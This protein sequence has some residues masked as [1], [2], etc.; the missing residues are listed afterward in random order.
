MLATPEAFGREAAIGELYRIANWWLDK[1]LDVE[2]GGFVGEIDFHGN[3]VPGASKGVILN[4]RILW[5]FSELAQFDNDVRYLDAANRAFN[6]LLEYFDD[7]VHGGAVWELSADGIILNGRKQVYAQCFCIYALTA[8][9]RLTSNP[10]ALAKALEYFGRLESTALDRKFGGFIDAFSQSWKSIDD[11]RLSAND[12]NVPKSMNTHLHVLE[13]YTALYKT[14][15]PA[16][17]HV[18]LRDALRAALQN[19]IENFCRHCIDRKSGHVALYFERDWNRIGTSISYGHDIEASWLLLE[20]AHTLGDAD[21]IREV[22]PLAERL[23][24]TCHDEAIGEQGQVFNTF[25]PST[26]TL[27]SESIW[28]VQAEALVGFVNAYRLTGKWKYRVAA[29]RVWNFVRQHHVDDVSGEW[30]WLSSLDDDNAQHH[31]KAGFW[32]A[33]YHNGRAMLQS[34]RIF[35]SIERSR[36]P[37]AAGLSV[38]AGSVSAGTVSAGV[39]AEGDTDESAGEL[40]AQ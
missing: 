21:T 15:E 33:P 4:S 27:A 30:H 28:W 10:R 19:A 17:T 11:Y 22:A 13:A 29:D 1:S 6:Y 7:P 8:Y 5:F 40:R 25:D 18:A 9:Y 32:K 16:V 37:I 31:Y 2:R 26:G 23:A 38:S 35:E 12:L 39:H 14:A 3:P 20:A 34:I 36:P 24:F